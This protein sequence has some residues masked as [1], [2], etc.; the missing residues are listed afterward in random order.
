M[1]DQRSKPKHNSLYGLNTLR[2]KTEILE[3][4]W[5]I[6]KAR[7]TAFNN[8]ITNSIVNALELWFNTI[9]SLIE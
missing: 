6:Y 8:L 1:N 5:F 3:F 7:K 9:T 4:K 2:T